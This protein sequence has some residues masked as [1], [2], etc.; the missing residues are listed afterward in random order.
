M[1]HRI[2]TLKTH[3]EKDNKLLTVLAHIADVNTKWSS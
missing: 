1:I 2:I 3:D